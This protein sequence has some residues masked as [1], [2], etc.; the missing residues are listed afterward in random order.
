MDWEPW[1]HLVHV[2]GAIVWVGGGVM[3]SVLGHRAR[4]RGD[5]TVIGDFAR[6]LSYAGLRLLTPA[7]IA[8]LVSGLALVLMSSDSDLTQ[9]W[10]LLALADFVVAF[11]IGAV[12]LSRSA[13]QM[14]RAAN[15]TG[16]LAAARLALGRWLLGYGV[17]L[18]ALAFA[19]WDMIFK[20]GT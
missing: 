10:I 19:L 20:P 16:D 3:L 18:L 14:D 12:Y 8:V 1:V 17:V 13:I 7:V 15:R 9:P 11:M 5:I 4:G 6:T 2:A